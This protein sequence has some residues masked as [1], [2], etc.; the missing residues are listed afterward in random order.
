MVFCIFSHVPYTC[1]ILT[2][3]R[4]TT[5][6]S[7]EESDD[8]DDDEAELQAELAKIKEEREAAAAKKALEEQEMELR[9]NRENAMRNNPLA[10]I[11]EN[12]AKV[13]LNVYIFLFYF[14]C[15]FLCCPLGTAI[16]RR[17]GEVG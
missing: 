11:E 12:S 5:H 3:P 1:T 9:A 10:L 2:S 14:V 6:N 7:D 8:E 13:A 4:K 17:R 16:Q 15:V